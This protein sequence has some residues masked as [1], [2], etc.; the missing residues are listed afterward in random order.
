MVNMALAQHMTDGGMRV[1]I[2]RQ[3]RRT[4]PTVLS[5][6]APF[7][8]LDREQRR[9]VAAHFAESNSRL[10]RECGID[11]GGTFFSWDAIDSSVRPNRD[12][13]RGSVGQRA[14]GGHAAHPEYGRRRPVSD[15]GAVR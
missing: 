10:A 13:W 15:A 5:D 14:R 7:V 12:S 1:Q 11:A 2:E 9:A 8:G 3:L 6:D 4:L